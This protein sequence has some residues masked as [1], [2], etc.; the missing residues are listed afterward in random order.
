MVHVLL[1]HEVTN[2]ATWKQEF[3]NGESFRANAGVKR[4]V[5][6]VRLIIQIM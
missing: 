6:T 5:F 4:L 1:S 3:D 2:F